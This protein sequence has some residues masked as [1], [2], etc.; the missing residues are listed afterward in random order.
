MSANTINSNIFRAYDIR[1][2][3]P[4]TLAEPD[5]YAIGQALALQLYSRNHD[6]GEGRNY[7]QK[8]VVARDSR[9]SSPHLH[10]A[11]VAGIVDTGT[12]VIDIGEA[13]TP[14]LYFA[15]VHWAVHSGIMITGSHNPANYNG[16]KITLAGEPLANEA[17]TKIYQ[18]ILNNQANGLPKSF[19][20]HPKGNLSYRDVHDDYL[21]AIMEKIKLPDQRNPANQLTIAIDAGNG[22]AGPITKALLSRWGC[23][24]IDLYCEPD[25]NFPNHHPD[26]SKPENLKDLVQAVATHKADIGLAFDGDG[27]RLGVITDQGEL[28]FPDH[29]LMLF[30]KYLLQDR[31]GSHIIFDVKCTDLLAQQIKAW[32]GKAEYYKTGHS[33]IKKYL[34]KTGALFAG[35]MSGH[36]F[37]ADRWYGFDD[38]LYSA[39]RLLEILANDKQTVSNLLAEFPQRVSTPEINIAVD[40]DEKFSLIEK[41]AEDPTLNQA[42]E[43]IKI[44]GIRINTPQSWGLVRAS[45]TTPVLVLRFEATDQDE[46]T[47]I[48]KLFRDALVR[49]KADIEI[50]F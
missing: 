18:D 26:P 39:A 28:I 29:L 47:R 12:D 6:S 27:D 4:E 9:L 23:K 24:T 40:E 19:A 13:T 46:L 37:F 8:I 7:P 15:S 14:M 17:I 31:P 30:A 16:F 45:N 11:L 42:G 33:L 25:G 35:E 32:G 50:C 34:K 1:G 5:A 48:K 44:D 38:A 20:K 43:A 10:K 3:Y 22:I 49:A 21:Q 41:L 2:I 36:I